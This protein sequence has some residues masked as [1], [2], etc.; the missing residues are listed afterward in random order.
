M[1]VQDEAYW[2]QRRANERA[3]AEGLYALIVQSTKLTIRLARKSGPVADFRWRAPPLSHRDQTKLLSHR[4][5]PLP[6]HSMVHK[7]E[8][9][10][11]VCG[12][13][14]YGKRGSHLPKFGP[15]KRTWHEACVTTYT[16]MTKPGSYA[17]ALLVGQGEKCA[18]SGDPIELHM[19]AY[20]EVDHRTPLYRVA[21][22][23]ADEPWFK[24]LRFW[25]LDNLQVITRAAH[26][27]KCAAEARERAGR[28]SVAPTQGALL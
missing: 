4:D 8:G 16:L 11:R 14:V 1:I 19:A 9:F 17:E 13:P 20:A 21:R 2:A 28:R 23:H 6:F 18:L 22:D 7:G 10:C 12:Q 25:L 15:S 27:E 5:P 3:R 26:V 24:L